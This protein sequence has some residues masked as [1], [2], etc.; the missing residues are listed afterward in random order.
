MFMVFLLGIN[1]PVYGQTVYVSNSGNDSYTKTQAQ[2]IG[3]PWKTIQ[4]ACNN[5]SPGNTIQIM[6]GTY[7]EQ[8]NM[9]VS[10]SAISG[11]ITLTNYS[12]GKVV[13]NG[14]ADSIT[15]FTLSNQ[16]YIKING[17]EFYN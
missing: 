17:L 7:Y 10:G 8:V 5:A 9:P 11:Y 2:S 13:L 3:T 4:H 12:G 16:S 15:L 6:A 14:N 1:L